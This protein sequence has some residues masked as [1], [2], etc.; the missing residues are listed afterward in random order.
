[1]RRKI[2]LFGGTFDPIHFGHIHLSLSLQEAHHL[3]QVIICPAFQSPNKSSPFKNIETAEKFHAH[4][5]FEMANLAI[6]D[7]PN[8][9]S[10]VDW[11]IARGGPSYMIDTVRLCLAHF[12]PEQIELYLLL[13]EDLASTLNSW[14]DSDL[15]FEY[16][17]P[18]IGSRVHKSLMESLDVN[19]KMYREVTATNILEISS[20]SVRARIEKK[21]YCGHLLPAKVL[22][23]IKLHSLYSAP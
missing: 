10:V 18:L 5:R 11:E 23:Y 15:L 13:G 16:A 4:H 7:I 12:L 14:K 3:D 1:M 8:N 6:Q 21:L 20:T 2:G 17:P 9:W 19:K 22:D